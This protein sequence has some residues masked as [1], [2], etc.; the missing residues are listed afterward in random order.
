[1][2]PGTLIGI[3]IALAVARAVLYL[4]P[5]VN[6]Q[7]KK[8]VVE[9]L[10]SI[11]VAGATA[12]FLIHFVIRS[13]YIP[14][15]SMEHT[16][17]INDYILVNEWVYHVYHPARG[18]IIVFRPPPEAGPDAEDKDYIKR[19]IA[20]A[21]DTFELR[22]DEVYVNGQPVNEPYKFV[23]GYGP[24][25]FGPLT[26]KPGCV[27][28]MGDNRHNSSDSRVWGQ[29]PVQRIIGKAAMIFFPPYRI[30]LLQ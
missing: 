22:D 24:P 1:M 26:I 17:E 16:L 30:R 11:I 7:G 9:Y 2:T 15:G 5:H 28:C 29:L 27:W 14:S 12:L 8:A 6:F 20:V 10:D 18:D 13:F 23:D 3:I 25:N 19:V 4:F 21:G